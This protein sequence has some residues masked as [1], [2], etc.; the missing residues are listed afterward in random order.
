[1]GYLKMIRLQGLE[2]EA[3]TIVAR[4]CCGLCDSSKLADTILTSD[5]NIMLL[6][7]DEFWEELP[8]EQHFSC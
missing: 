7:A 3:W 5:D 2:L 1:M 6:R 4:C 8:I